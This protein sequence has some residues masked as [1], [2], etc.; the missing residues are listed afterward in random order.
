MH[1]IG[2]HIP[3]IPNTEEACTLL[4]RKHIEEAI[5]KKE[6]PG[7]I[8]PKKDEYYYNPHSTS[9]NQKT[10]KKHDFELKT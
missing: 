7:S 8:D 10:D 1:T 9:I 6:L 5:I 4:I 3:H 2:P